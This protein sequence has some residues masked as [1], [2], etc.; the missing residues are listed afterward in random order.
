[1]PEICHIPKLLDVN[2]WAKYANMQLLSLMMQP[3]SQYTIDNE[4]ATA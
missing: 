3:E 4:D 2:L 1:M